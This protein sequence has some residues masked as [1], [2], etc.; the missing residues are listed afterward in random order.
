M[1]QQVKLWHYNGEMV[2]W[3]D[4]QQ[5]CKDQKTQIKKE[6][7]PTALHPSRWLDWC[8]PEDEKKRDRKIAEV[9]VF[10]HL[11]C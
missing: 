11:I 9:V 5:K 3:Y 2:E 6:L 10:D 7:M 4:G 1:E 8:V